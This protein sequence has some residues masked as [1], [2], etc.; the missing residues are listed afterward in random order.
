MEYCSI[1]KLTEIINLLRGQ[2][3]VAFDFE[4]APT[5]QWRE[6]PRAALDAHKSVIVGCSFATDD[7]AVFYVP[8][9]HRAGQ[10]VE[11]QEELWQFLKEEVFESG[12]VVKI[13]HNLAFE[14]MFLYAKGIVV[15]EPCYDT[16]AA[17]QLSMKSRYEFRTLHDSGLK[18]LATSLF[19]ADMP[20]FESVTAGR[21]F[22]EMNP[23]EYETI[24]YACAD[25][26]YTLKLYH[27]FNAWFEKYLPG[28]KQVTE[29]LE[30]PAAVYVGV[31]KY[32]GVP[33]DVPLM[34]AAKEKAEAEIARLREDIRSIIG[35]V[36]IG[37]NCSTTAFKNYLYKTLQLPVLKKTDRL[38]P[39]VDDETLIRLQDY[40]K[41]QKAE[42]VPL[43]DLVLEYRKWQK[44][45]STYLDGYLQHVNSATGCIHPDLMP[46]ATET[47]RFASRNPNMQNSPQPGQDPI[48]VRNFITAPDGWMLVEADYSQAEIRLCAY[49]SNDKV[50]LDAYRNG[51]D[52]HAITTSAVYGISLEE[53]GDHSNP[54]YK[55]RR[56]VAKSTMFGIM[57][58]IGGA[59]LAR[60]LYTNAGITLTKEE[61][62][63]Y[64]DGIL[65]KYTD[66]AAW[67]ISQINEAADCMYVE[68]ALG[69]RRYLLGI[70]SEQ[71]WERSSAE[72]MAINTPV[73]GLGADC[74]KYAMGRL[75][76]E[77]RGR[78]DIKPI[79]T[80]HDSLVFLVREDKVQE[81]MKLVKRCMETPP[82]LPGFMPLVADVSAG[83]KYGE[84]E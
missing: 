10:N 48:G 27:K 81:A 74:L 82:P 22:D 12:S 41:E 57:Y 70:R 56:T 25:S 33:M 20:S 61:C 47:G 65:H 15:Q 31:M 76:S 6:D 37:S 53:A 60:N 67:Q 52:V 5:E 72:R 30:S 46:L 77:L 1:T 45:M 7:G 32:N 64:I 4:T 80:V 84:L 14:S 63:S 73:Q 19:G 71:K 11:R 54:Q 69:R 24:R 39:S 42:I 35:D 28:H 66:M 38:L 16:I 2:T 62:D 55:H 59:G 29:M 44:L 79:L 43:F 26:D 21:M 36:E 8:M 18:L 83:K 34:Q 13:A 17:A 75:N 50:L 40:C 51:V 68:T 9:N 23:Q 58:G 49:L 78:D 3:V